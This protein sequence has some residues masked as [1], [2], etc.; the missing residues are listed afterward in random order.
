MQDTVEGARDGRH[1]LLACR[2]LAIYMLRLLVL[3]A[4]LL[5]LGS[6]PVSGQ[7]CCCR[8]LTG[9]LKHCLIAGATSPLPLT[10]CHATA[11]A[12]VVCFH[13]VFCCCKFIL[14][15]FPDIFLFL[16]AL[17]PQIAFN[18][19]S[20]ITPG[21]TEVC[22]VSVCVCVP[23]AAGETTHYDAYPHPL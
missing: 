14:R 2:S 23:Q 9:F 13:L 22:P 17:S 8:L 21:H 15:R 19:F 18:S 6:H 16:L 4:L 7:C 5:L 3:L 10:S 20:A 1:G 12:Y 11:T